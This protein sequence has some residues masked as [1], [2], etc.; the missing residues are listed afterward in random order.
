MQQ[1]KLTHQRAN[2]FYVHLYQLPLNSFHHHVY[3]S[4]RRHHHQRRYDG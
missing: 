2:I 4:R 3:I 1:P